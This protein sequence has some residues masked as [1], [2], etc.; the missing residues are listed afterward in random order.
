MN[1][2][3]DLPN[4][5]S[6]NRSYRKYPEA[7][8]REVSRTKNVY[9]F[10]DL[11]I[12]R[13]TAQ[14]WVKRQKPF[15]TAQVVDIEYAYKKKSEFLEKELSKE[16]ALRILLE[17]VRR[18][19]PFDFRVKKLKNKQARAQ[20]IAA[21]HECLE[22]HKVSHCL[23]AIGLPE[24]SYRRWA[25]EVSLCQKAKS[26]CGRRKASQLTENEIAAMKK[27]VHSRKYAHAS[28]T[29]LHLLAQRMG[30]LFC[31]LDTWYKYIRTYE[32][33]R[34]WV[35]VERNYK[36][37]GIRAT[38]PN[39]IW[40]I[41]VTKV[42]VGSLVF[43]IQAVIDN[44]S[45]FILAWSITTEMNAKITVENLDQAR[46]KA[47]ELLNA[48]EK[49]N[50]MMDPGKENDNH[51]VLRFI[52]SKNLT[53]TLAQ[54]DVHYSNSMIEGLFHS[55]KNKFLYYHKIKGLEDLTRK[56][57]FFFRQHNEVVPQAVLKGGKPREVFISQ[58]GKAELEELQKTKQKP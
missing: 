41:D 12:P 13:T 51:A 4:F 2:A 40:H 53:R 23:N 15:G 22:F 45:R 26:P 39:E 36:K 19:F 56:V 55:L 9:L 52:T 44:F 27:F 46:T 31:S 3:L 49:S 21:I 7:V 16:K 17:T 50:V 8:K 35:K 34:P 25:S 20:I 58:W 38:K 30:E 33:K 11:Q 43:Y 42:S 32:W 54:V 48:E 18:V 6:E 1:S 47:S 37:I 10:P 29:S 14:Y 5:S 57:N 24:S 28:I